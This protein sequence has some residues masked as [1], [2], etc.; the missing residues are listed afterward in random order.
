MPHLN[1]KVHLVI[2]GVKAHYKCPT[3]QIWVTSL[4]HRIHASEPIDLPEIQR[5]IHLEVKSFLFLI[6]F[7]LLFLNFRF[8]GIQCAQET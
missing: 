2:S 3:I 7:L 5:L 6:T 8:R 1:H 4:V